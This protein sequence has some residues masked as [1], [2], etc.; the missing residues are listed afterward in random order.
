[1]TPFSLFG[2]DSGWNEYSNQ[3]VTVGHSNGLQWFIVAAP[4]DSHGKDNN[5]LSQPDPEFL[6]IVGIKYPKQS[7]NHQGH[8]GEPSL[9][10]KEPGSEAEFMMKLPDNRFQALKPYSHKVYKVKLALKD[11][12]NNVSQLNDSGKRILNSPIRTGDDQNVRMGGCIPINDL[13]HLECYT[14]KINFAPVQQVEPAPSAPAP[15]S[16]VPQQIPTPIQ[17]QTPPQFS[18]RKPLGIALVIAACALGSAGIYWLK[19]KKEHQKQTN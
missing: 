19:S 15:S 2:M 7:S 12:S 1:M 10:I 4:S 3:Y 8:L 17:P 14:R 11:E 13:S 5:P 9:H 6:P 16:A 18:H